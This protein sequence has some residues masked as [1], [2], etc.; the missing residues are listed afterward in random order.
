MKALQR[1]SAPSPV[2]GEDV[3]GIGHTSLRR[4]QVKPPAWPV[5]DYKKYLDE[6]SN[7]FRK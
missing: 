7:Y 2:E 3:K 5:L 6:F 1:K 4:S